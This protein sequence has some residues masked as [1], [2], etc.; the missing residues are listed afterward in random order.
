MKNQYFG[1]INDFKKYGLLRLFGKKGKIRTLICW[2]LTPNEP[3]QDG[4]RIQYL[5]EPEKWRIFDPELFDFLRQ[6]VIISKDRSIFSIERSGLLH[7]CSFYSDL[8]TDEIDARKKYINKISELSQSADLLFFDPDNGLEVKSVP[9][10]KRKS[11]KYLYFDEVNKLFSSGCSLM[12]YQH[13]PPKPRIPYIN[14]I[15]T[16][17]KNATNAKSVFIYSTQFSLFLVIP[18][19]EHQLIFKNINEGIIGIWG[20]QL[21]VAKY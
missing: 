7:H 12:I 11:S 8:V 15:V 18:Q 20:N 3:K 2:L 10:G 21:E 4:H 6:Q 16:R 14:E 13:L 19:S 9:F 5:N 1:D 17:A